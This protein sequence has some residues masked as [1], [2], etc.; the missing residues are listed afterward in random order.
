MLVKCEAPVIF[1][2]WKAV[3]T[4]TG[5]LAGLLPMKESAERVMMPLCKTVKEKA[6]GVI[7]TENHRK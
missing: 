3:S 6:G 7:Y 4:I 1:H 5:K 2:P